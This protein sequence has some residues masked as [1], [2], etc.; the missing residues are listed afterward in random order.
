MRRF[1]VAIGP[2]ETEKQKQS[3]LRQRRVD[4]RFSGFSFDSNRESA[5]ESI[6]RFS[7]RY[8]SERRL[9]ASG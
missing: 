6:G 3:E 4:A 2:D 5:I 7:D 1:A 9:N 8:D